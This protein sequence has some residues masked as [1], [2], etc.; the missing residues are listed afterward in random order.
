MYFST[1][2]EIRAYFL[3]SNRYEL[4][5]GNLKQAIGIASDGS[6]MYWTDIRSGFESI[7]KASPNGKNKEVC[8]ANFFY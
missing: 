2:N 8:L 4:V 6:H 7:Y 1:K 3:N 5:A